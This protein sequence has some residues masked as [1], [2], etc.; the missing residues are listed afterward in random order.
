MVCPSYDP[1]EKQLRVATDDNQLWRSFGKIARVA[2]PLGA[3]PR[4]KKTYADS[5]GTL[6]L[7]RFFDLVAVHELAHSFDQQGGA[8]F[9]AVWLSEIF[10]NLSLHAFIANARPSQLGD[11]TTFPEAQRRVTVF[12]LMMRLRGYRSLEDFELHYPVGSEEPM[13]GV[14]YGRYQVRLHVLARE[15]FDEHGEGALTRLWMLGL[16]E[17]QRRTSAWDHYLEHRTLT[18]WAG[19][20]PRRELAALL[21]SDVS[22]RLGEAI[23]GWD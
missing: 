3:F 20:M 18:G 14:N 15:V 10:A 12:N 5:D 8:A 19:R 11:L 2:S 4:L 6:Q 21:Q 7:R 9:P 22:R 23:A 17:A 16:S 1:I 13:N